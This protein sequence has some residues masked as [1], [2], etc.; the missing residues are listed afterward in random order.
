[1]LFIMNVPLNIL[2][3]QC[4]EL[5]CE[6]PN[7]S[8]SVKFLLIFFDNFSRYTISSSLSA[9]P[10]FLLYSLMFIISTESSGSILTKKIF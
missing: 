8:E 10:S 2:C 4:S 6:K 1:M 9:R 3:R 7:T 5:T